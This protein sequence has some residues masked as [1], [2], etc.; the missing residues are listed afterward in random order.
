MYQY[1]DILIHLFIL[2]KNEK[3]KNGKKKNGKRQ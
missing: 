2:L 3:W 1:Y